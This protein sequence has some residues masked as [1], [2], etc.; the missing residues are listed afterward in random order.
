MLRGEAAGVGAGVVVGDEG[1]AARPPTVG[2]LAGRCW[3]A[4]GLER[5]EEVRVDE[6]FVEQV[7][8][9]AV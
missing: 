8:L 6:G 5:E 3:P 2:R 4:V 7:A 1:A 9:P